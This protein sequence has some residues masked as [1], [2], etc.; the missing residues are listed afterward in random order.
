MNGSEIEKDSFEEYPEIKVEGN[1]SKNNEIAELSKRGYQLLKEGD[2]DGAKDEFKKILELENNNNYALV[3]LG[4]SERKLNHFNDAIDYYTK[5]LSF[6]PG[7]NYALFGL[8][9]CY[10]TLNQFHKAIDIWEQYLVHDD[11]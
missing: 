1:N 10:K 3:G 5:C 9:D 8:A 6:Y 7:N 4:D 2:V 11:R